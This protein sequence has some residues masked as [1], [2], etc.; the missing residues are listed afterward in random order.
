M[1]SLNLFKLG[2]LSAD[3]LRWPSTTRLPTINASACWIAAHPA[4]TYLEEAPHHFVA[5][6]GSEV[7][8]GATGGWRLAGFPARPPVYLY[9]YH[10]TGFNLCAS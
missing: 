1:P 4:L 5:Q 7:R 2:L 6:P 10:I 9:I 8:A 3:L